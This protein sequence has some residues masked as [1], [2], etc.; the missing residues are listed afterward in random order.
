MLGSELTSNP[1]KYPR[2][3]NCGV[4]SIVSFQAPTDGPSHGSSEYATHEFLAVT[5]CSKRLMRFAPD[6]SDPVP[7][8]SSR[9]PGLGS[10]F[11]STGCR[12]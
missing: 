8:P 6:D 12:S 10:T 7:G 3:P 1:T 11:P 4:T 2:M 5:L 9:S